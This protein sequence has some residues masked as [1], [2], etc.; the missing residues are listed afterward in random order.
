MQVS[1]RLLWPKAA[2]RPPLPPE[3]PADVA[4]DYS[5]AAL[6][7]ADSCNAAAALA[8]RCLQNVLRT[9]GGV[10][11]ESNKLYDEIEA[12]SSDLPSYMAGSL[13]DLRELGNDAAHP[14][15]SGVTGE[16]VDVDSRE[17]EWTLDILDLL[18]DHY[19]V[20]PQKAREIRERLQGRKDERKA[21]Q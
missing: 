4:R 16:I 11:V 9:A 13:H 7:L 3:V 8:R 20:K 2:A 17:A 15:R 18:F 5:E 10:K 1:P 21:Q 19:F 14:N 6:V 12:A